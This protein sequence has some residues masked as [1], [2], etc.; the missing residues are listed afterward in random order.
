M[1][2]YSTLEGANS[3]ISRYAWKIEPG[4]TNFLGV[5]NVWVILLVTW[6]LTAIAIV[7]L[8]ARFWIR[9]KMYKTWLSDDWLMFVAL[10]SL[11]NAIVVIHFP[12]VLM[13]SL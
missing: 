10:V 2:L 7:V 13:L 1:I 6:L 5:K 11:R 12:P 3:L 9:W 4:D 8:T